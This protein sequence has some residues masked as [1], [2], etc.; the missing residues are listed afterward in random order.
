MKRVKG[1]NRGG[2]P[3]SHFHLSS[4]ICHPSFVSRR[5]NSEVQQ[6][7]CERAKYSTGSGIV[8]SQ[9]A[10]R[11]ATVPLAV[12]TAFSMPQVQDLAET[13]PTA[14]AFASE[15][16]M[17]LPG[18][19]CYLSAVATA[20]GSVIEPKG[21]VRMKREGGGRW[22]YLFLLREVECG[23]YRYRYRTR[24]RLA[25]CEEYVALIVSL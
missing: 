19:T 4:V 2:L 16:R 10:A 13:N 22:S 25:S 7:Q 9:P 3:P 21:C 11:A 6:E 14:A 17:L 15:M 8:R 12:A 1:A 23:R 18:E 5:F 24:S 20:P